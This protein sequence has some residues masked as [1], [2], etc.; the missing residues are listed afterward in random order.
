MRKPEEKE[1]KK[2][3]KKKKKIRSIQKLVKKINFLPRFNYPDF[4]LYLFD[5]LVLRRIVT[6][7]TK[8]NKLKNAPPILE[9]FNVYYGFDEKKVQK[10]RNSQ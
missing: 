10:N 8:I 1:E 6:K 7:I 2:E 4:L 3:K 9:I 5:A